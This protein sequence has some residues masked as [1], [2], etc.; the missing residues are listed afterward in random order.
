M[1][2]LT[3]KRPSTRSRFDAPAP[4]GNVD[5]DMVGSGSKPDSGFTLL[6]MIVSLIIMGIVALVVVAPIVQAINGFIFVQGTRSVVRNAELAM[7]R[8]SKEL[9]VTQKSSITGTA[10][11]LTFASLHT[12]ANAT[13]TALLSGSQLIL[14]DNNNNNYVLANNINSLSFAYY[15]TYSG[16][17]SSTWTTT[18]MIVYMSITV[19]GPGNAPL[20]FST[21]VAPRN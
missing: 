4:A 9:V 3:F 16:T 12:G 19:T 17:S 21:R 14:Q 7:L 20:T 8:L 2:A 5:S 6:E 1:P 15:S 10:S 18:S 11:S 13:Y